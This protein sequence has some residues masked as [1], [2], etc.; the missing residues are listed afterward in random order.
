MVCFIKIYN[1]IARLMITGQW[2]YRSS[3]TCLLIARISNV[4]LNRFKI[5]I[6]LNETKNRRNPAKS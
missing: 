3:Y 4:P 1:F 2:L 6:L 5:D